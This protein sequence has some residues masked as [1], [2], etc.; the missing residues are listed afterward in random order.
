MAVRFDGMNV[1][2]MAW[3]EWIHEGE[4]DTWA[5]GY[6]SDGWLSEK[7]GCP[8]TRYRPRDL[9]LLESWEGLCHSG[10]E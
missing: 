1:G 7:G 4:D 3:V 6:S 8:Y 9:P 10:G 5:V 2:I